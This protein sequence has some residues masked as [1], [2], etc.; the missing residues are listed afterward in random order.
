[1]SLRHDIMSSLLWAVPKRL[2][3]SLQIHCILLCTWCTSALAI[4]SNTYAASGQILACSIHDE[5]PTWK[6]KSNAS[7][8]KLAEKGISVHVLP[9]KMATISRKTCEDCEWFGSNTDNTAAPGRGLCMLGLKGL[10]FVV[11]VSSRWLISGE[12]VSK[13]WTHSPKMS[14]LWNFW[15]RVESERSCTRILSARLTVSLCTL[16]CRNS[17]TQSNPS[18]RCIWWANLCQKERS[19]AW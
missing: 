14:P 11:E 4:A 19:E 12:M 5:L 3:V 7:R 13:P 17:I 15:S 2:Q 1:M 6:I 18:A 9:S 8:S 16:L 10:K